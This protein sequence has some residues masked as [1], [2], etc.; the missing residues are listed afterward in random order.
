MFEHRIL[1]GIA[2][3]QARIESKIN[4]LLNEPDTNVD[5]THMEELMADIKQQV[6]DLVE[7]ARSQGTVIDSIATIVQSF[8]DQLAVAQ[9][10]L[11]AGDEA[12]ASATLAEITAS[13]DANTT[14]LLGIAAAE[15]TGAG[16]EGHAAGM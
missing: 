16:D 10:Q 2:I 15:N 3:R 8:K 12:A 5:L 14:R 6:A 1:V 9:G 7:K 4:R 11:N 13:F